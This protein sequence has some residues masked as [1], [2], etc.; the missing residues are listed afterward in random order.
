[1]DKLI[2]NKKTYTLILTGIFLSGLF[3]RLLY[4]GTK[5]FYSDEGVTWYIALG[6][7]SSDTHPPLYFWILGSFIKIFGWSESAGRLPSVLF[8]I[9]MVP[10]FYKIGVK[11][12]NPRM[13]FYAAL[14]TGL[15]AFLV[16]VSQE[17][18]MYGL[19]G[20]ETVLTL[21]FFLNIIHEER[22]RFK[23]WVGF[24]LT[25][26]AGLYTHSVFAFLLLYLG[27]TILIVSLKNNKRKFINFV[28]SIIVIIATYLPQ[29]LDTLSKAK[30]H[31]NV[32]ADS[33]WQIKV[34]IL[35]VA[36]SLISFLFG[37]YF[38]NLP[39]SALNYAMSHPLFA[40]LGILMLMI[41]AVML[42]QGIKYFSRRIRTGGIHFLTARIL[43]GM[44]IFMTL[45]FTILNVST[46]R[47]MIFIYVPFIF[48]I[49]SF[50][51]DY[52][53]K[54]KTI[55]LLSFLVLTVVSLVDY[56]RHPYFS[57]ERADWRKAGEVLKNNLNSED[58]IFFIQPRNGYYTLLFYIP[59]MK[60]E[61]FYRKRPDYPDDKPGHHQLEWSEYTKPVADWVKEIAQQN[62]RLW[63][64]GF[65]K[66]WYDATYFNERYTVNTYPAGDG[67]EVH[68]Y[69]TRD[70]LNPKNSSNNTF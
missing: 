9:L 54:L 21:W 65:R 34:N 13:G 6:E 11:F 42:F 8:G 56:Y 44:I 17:M 30:I 43:A 18:R 49:A 29:F 53:G 51:A 66:A 35:R 5:C 61:V 10:F 58:K 60:N 70:G 59:D 46:A 48:I 32:F 50:L 62:S 38:I 7:I 19:L 37:N 52:K 55:I 12:F 40:F 24:I 64:V 14:I 15:S 20:F 3:L 1:M 28:L 68:L 36:K 4:L 41:S 57:Y 63:V 33:F 31:P 69:Q 39:G 25:S 26:T 45:L 2:E 16:L 22:P 67:F 47:Q 23:W 27:L